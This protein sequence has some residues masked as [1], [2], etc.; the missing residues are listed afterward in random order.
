LETVIPSSRGRRRPLDAG[1]P[2]QWKSFG[3]RKGT[4]DAGLIL[5]PRPRRWEKPAAPARRPV[6]VIYGN[7]PQ[8]GEMP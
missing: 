6:V 1:K 5:Q 4:H 3:A 8:Q 2:I 7:E